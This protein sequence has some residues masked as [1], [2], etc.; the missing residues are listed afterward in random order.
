MHYSGRVFLLEHPENNDI[1]TIS[2]LNF[3]SFFNEYLRLICQSATNMTHRNFLS[4]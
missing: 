2:D 4:H 3:P 1:A